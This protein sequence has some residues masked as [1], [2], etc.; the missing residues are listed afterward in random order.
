M[1]TEMLR[2]IVSIVYKHVRGRSRALKIPKHGNL[3]KLILYKTLN[4]SLKL[5]FSFTLKFPSECLPNVLLKKKLVVLPMITFY[6]IFV[7]MVSFTIV[8]VIRND[9]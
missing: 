1:A 4:Q 3:I 7:Y 8:K 9:M 6:C 2:H 5:C